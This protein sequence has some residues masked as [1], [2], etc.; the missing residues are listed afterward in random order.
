MICILLFK[1]RDNSQNLFSTLVASTKLILQN[2]NQHSLVVSSN[3][4]SHFLSIYNQTE[5]THLS[6]PKN[7]FI[8]TCNSTEKS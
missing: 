8:L 7:S 4:L 3:L 1:N 2:G 6:T 5:D